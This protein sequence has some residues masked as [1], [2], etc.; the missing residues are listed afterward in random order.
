[1]VGILLLF[2]GVLY[3]LVAPVFGILVI[4]VFA[5][6]VL[7]YGI[8]SVRASQSTGSSPFSGTAPE[9]P[10]M[11]QDVHLMYQDTLSEYVKNFGVVRGTLLHENRLKAY[12]NDGFSREEAIRKLAED[13][14]Y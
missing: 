2:G 10:D 9:K 13:M 6:P 8:H 11:Y 7:A 3:A 12:I 4:A 1:M 14:E 5:V